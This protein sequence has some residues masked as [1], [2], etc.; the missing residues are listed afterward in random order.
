MATKLDT[1]KA[2]LGGDASKYSNDE[3]NTYLMFAEN[4][5]L[6]HLYSAMTRPDDAVLMMQHETVQIQAVIAGLNAQGAEGEAMHS[7]NGISRTFKYS[8]MIQYIESHIMPYVG[9]I[10]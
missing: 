5:I 7:E 10:R 3:L 6:D 1:L 4:A 9:G 2:L 8:D